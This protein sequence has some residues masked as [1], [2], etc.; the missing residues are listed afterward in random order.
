M[1]TNNRDRIDKFLIDLVS[2]SG[3]YGEPLGT[4]FH[5]EFNLAKKQF[6]NFDRSSPFNADLPYESLLDLAK[7]ITCHN[8]PIDSIK[9]W[10]QEPRL[11]IELCEYLESQL[12]SLSFSEVEVFEIKL[13]LAF[14]YMYADYNSFDSKA[15]EIFQELLTIYENQ[16]GNQYIGH[17]YLLILQAELCFDA[18]LD[19]MRETQ[20]LLNPEYVERLKLIDKI[21]LRRYYNETDEEMQ[22]PVLRLC[23]DYL[24]KFINKYGDSH[25]E[26]EA[27][28]S[29]YEG[30]YG[31]LD[32]WYSL[33]SGHYEELLTYNCKVLGEECFG[34]QILRKLIEIPPNGED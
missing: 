17:F 31:D 1:E 13:C 8:A 10:H 26:T 32:T 27:A 20:K 7:R 14:N 25:L 24:S 28:R 12:G 22:Y 16:F 33:N 3:D 5:D 6:L 19:E 30:I 15:D 4:K 11:C 21:E 2:P 23:V 34:A 29:I 18:N 9:L